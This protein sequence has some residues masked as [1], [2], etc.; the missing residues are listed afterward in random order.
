MD[1]K[2]IEEL[3]R[4][5][6][7]GNPNAEGKKLYQQWYDSFQDDP[8]IL[9]SL[10][11][12]KV[13]TELFEMIKNKISVEGEGFKKP[14]KFILATN[15]NPNR[16][17][18]LRV[19]AA[20][21]VLIAVSV[22]FN[23]FLPPKEIVHRTAF[24]ERLNFTLPDGTEV[25]LNAHSTLKYFSNDPRTVKLEGEAFFR[26]KKKPESGAKFLV[27]TDDLTVE[28]LGTVFNVNSRDEVTQV[29]LEEGKVVLKLNNGIQKEMK[30]GN[31]VSFSSKMNK[32]VEEKQ[33]VRVELHTSW[34][35]GTLIFD[36][37]PLRKAMQKIE[38][39]YGLKVV[40][41]NEESGNKTING[42][43]PMENLDI[44]IKTIEKSA[45]VII[46]KVDNQLVIHAID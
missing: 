26:V 24:G 4:E 33:T 45:G 42:G 2:K 29:V 7:S 36:N 3:L 34:K 37:L 39:T 23:L 43:V 41:Q 27:I 6:L 38:E 9:E 46:E 32:V 17:T 40:F 31:L 11:K 20:I 16:R 21:V 15:R 10:E 44:C 14:D 13:K 35:D 19:A 5:Y 22:L 8:A 12:K 28:V 30:P 18:W 1:K 25:D